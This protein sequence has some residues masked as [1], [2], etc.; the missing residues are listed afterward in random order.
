MSAQSHTAQRLV[1]VGLT[2]L[3]ATQRAAGIVL[4][5]PWVRIVG[6][7]ALISRHGPTN[8]DGSF[9]QPRGKVGADVSQEQGYHVAR[10]TGLAIFGSLSRALGDIDR[11]TARTRVFGM[12]STAPGFTNMPAA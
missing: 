11:I 10:L 5:F 8:A 3:A 7:R 9:A 1:E 6:P 4:P 2:L 12:V